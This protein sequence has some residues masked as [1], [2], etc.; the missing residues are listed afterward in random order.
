MNGAEE[1]KE[2]PALRS[3]RT[4]PL[5]ALP[6]AMGQERSEGKQERALGKG[7]YNH[8]KGSPS[9]VHRQGALEGPKP[10]AIDYDLG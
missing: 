5:P 7:G 9:G 1:E 2:A 3:S 10:S 6:S 8:Q 4:A